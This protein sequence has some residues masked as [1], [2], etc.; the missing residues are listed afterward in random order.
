MLQH[1][2]H[3]TL[4]RDGRGGAACTGTLH[5]DEDDAVLIALKGNVAAIL[6]NG[7]ADARIKHFLDLRHDLGILAFMR[8]MA[9]LVIA[10]ADGKQNRRA[11]GEMLHDRTEQ[12]RLHMLP[13]ATRFGDCDE[14]AAEKDTGHMFH[15]EETH[16]ERRAL[17]G[18]PRGKISR[19][20]FAQHFAAGQKLQGRR[21]GRRL[22]LDKH[23]E[24]LCNMIAGR[25]PAA[26]PIDGPAGRRNQGK[27]ETLVAAWKACW[28]HPGCHNS[29]ETPAK[30]RK[31]QARR[32]RASSL[33]VPGT[34][35][36]GIGNALSEAAAAMLPSGPGP[37]LPLPVASTR[38]AISL[39]SLISCINCSSRRPSRISSSGM[40][41]A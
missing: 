36:T 17:G 27:A 1:V 14:I 38:I 25:G 8:G 6:R 2:L 24:T 32:R 9:V 41:P 19:A 7:G 4:Q 16:G 40:M 21:I 22:G 26:P 3:A 11:A 37:S 10:A 29:R 18:I 39:S 20:T 15:R 23:R 30:P 33:S 12:G 35:V 34:T 28:R 13:L 5:V 31:R